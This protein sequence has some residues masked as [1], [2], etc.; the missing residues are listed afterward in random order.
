MVEY[1][2]SADAFSAL[3]FATV[4]RLAA[5][6]LKWQQG[7]YIL[8]RAFIVLSLLLLTLAVPL[9]FEYGNTV[10]LWTVESTPMYFFGLRQQRPHICLGAFVVYSL[11]AL[12]QISGYQEGESTVLQS[13][14][15]T[16]P[17]AL[18]DGAAIYL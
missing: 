17:L 8:R 3:G 11:A 1:W 16:T 4:R 2:P 12:I 14:R 15:F 10:I 18:F 7:L 5:L 9:H 13:R 6:T